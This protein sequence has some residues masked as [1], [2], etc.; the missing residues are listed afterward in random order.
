MLWSWRILNFKKIS[1]YF[2]TYRE[3][4]PLFV[5]Y[6]TLQAYNNNVLLFPLQ[7][8]KQPHQI[9]CFD[10]FSVSKRFTYCFEHLHKENTKLSVKVSASHAWIFLSTLGFLWFLERDWKE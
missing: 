6:M 7:I 10:Q 5:K 1:P 3:I 2:W 8:W 4:T 9:K